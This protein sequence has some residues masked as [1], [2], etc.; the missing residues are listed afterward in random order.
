MP[1]LGIVRAG[2]VAAERALGQVPPTSDATSKAY[3][4]W[5][6]LAVAEE[7][8]VTPLASSEQVHN[9]PLVEA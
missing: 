2:A 5:E 7:L 3:V 4:P 6:R 8:T 1:L 9:E